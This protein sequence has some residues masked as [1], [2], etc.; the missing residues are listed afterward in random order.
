MVDRFEERR[1][2]RE[3]L[4]DKLSESE[5]GLALLDKSAWVLLDRCLA[6]HLRGLFESRKELLQKCP[7]MAQ[8]LLANAI[9]KY[10]NVTV[11]WLVSVG[12][13]Q[14]TAKTLCKAARCMSSYRYTNHVASIKKMASFLALRAKREQL[15]ELDE[16]GTPVYAHFIRSAVYLHKTKGPVQTRTAWVL[17]KSAI[18]RLIRVGEDH[19]GSAMFY[20]RELQGRFPPNEPEHAK[21]IQQFFSMLLESNK[22]NLNALDDKKW[23][24]LATNLRTIRDKRSH[25]AQA[26]VACEQ[27]TLLLDA[28]AEIRVEGVKPNSRQADELFQGIQHNRANPK[29]H[30]L[31]M[32]L[33]GM[34]LPI[35]TTKFQ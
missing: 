8:Y 25:P 19:T 10:D 35:D 30:S 31:V 20:N 16:D 14:P 4:V 24:M 21:R 1:V 28:G 33:Y 26:Q 2:W 9:F 13:V 11:R 7:K 5:E 32:R 34:V 15:K 3:Q 27:A 12:K 18:A 17:K 23:T 22:V 29:I 6:E